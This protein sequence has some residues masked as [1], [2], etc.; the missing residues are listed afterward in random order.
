MNADAEDMRYF[1]VLAQAGTLARAAHELGVDHTT[2]SRRIQRLEHALGIRLFTRT[3]TGWALNSNGERLLPAAR[4]VALGF[5]VF[6]EGDPTRIGP[7]EWT[8]LSSDGFA[9]NILAPR[10]G[11]LLAD[12]RIILHIISAAS[13]ATQEGVTFDAAVVRNRPSSPSVRSTLL[14]AYEIGLYASQDYLDTHPSIRRIDDLAGHVISWYSEDPIAGIPEIDALRPN[15]PNHIRLQSNNLQVHEQAALA[16]VGLA[17]MPV[18][19]AVRHDSLVRVLSDDLAYHGKYWTVLPTAQLRW[20][21]TER[22]QE[23]LEDAVRRAG[24]LLPRD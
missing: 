22:V 11:E 19:T 17:L 21:V 8:V 3:R 23:F 6:A 15:I 2:V 7:E 14:A 4:S 18:Y 9:A 16:G 1:Y 12:G 5:D 10:T 24:L 13:L 20:K